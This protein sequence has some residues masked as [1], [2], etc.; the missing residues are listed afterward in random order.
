MIVIDANVLSLFLYPSSSVPNDFK[1]KK[2]I[3]GARER[4]Q[5]LISE[6]ESNGDLVVI[7]APVL[8]EALVVAA[9]DVGPYVDVLEKSPHFQVAPFG[10]KAAIELALH[11]KA[12]KAAG[13]KRDGLAADECIWDKVNFDRQIVAIA[14]VVGALVIYSTDR[15]VHLHA[16]KWGIVCKNISDIA[17]PQ[18]VLE[19]FNEPEEEAR[20]SEPASPG[21]PGG[22]DRPVEGE[23]GAETAEAEE[24]D[25]SV[26]L[27]SEDRKGGCPARS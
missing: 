6:I 10:Q 8:S 23:A 24:I 20:R 7:P 16:E 9:P 1:T 15:H 11:L 27:S 19:L 13:D 22:G 4:V 18:P 25:L 2:P 14:K 26:E 3:P 5:A 21:I 17:E 12:A